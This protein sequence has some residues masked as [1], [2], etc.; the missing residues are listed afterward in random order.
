MHKA[1]TIEFN[2][3]AKF[4]LLEVLGSGACGETVHIRDEGMDADFV[5]KKY[6]PIISEEENPGLFLDLL[7]R[8]RDE[9]RIL[10]RLNHPNVVRVF[11][12]FDYSEYKTSYI[13]MEYVSGLELLDYLK[14]NPANADRVFEGVVDGFTHLQARG[15][16]HRDI[17]PANILIDETS[18]PKIID[19]GFGKEIG[20]GQ[21][22]DDRKSISLNWWCETPPEFADNIYDFQT[23]VYFVGKLFQL[24][25]QECGLSDFKYRL[26]LISMCESDRSRRTQS[27]EDVKRSINEGKFAE[28][29]FSDGEV[30]TYRNFAGELSE[31]VS[32][33]QSDARFDRDPTKVLVKLE[34]LY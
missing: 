9:A 19:F 11:N 6:L 20:L 3:P 12:Y 34:A 22:E 30:E 21:R 18:T 24:A 27:F 4:T 28:L 15:V 29:S 17:R 8:F 13:V 32:S 2:R 23:E 7:G 33:I 5:A 14:K 26:L 10:F 16:L 25:I 1:K 31:V